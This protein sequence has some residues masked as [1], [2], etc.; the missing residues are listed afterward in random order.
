[1]ALKRS[2]KIIL[3]IIFIIL[4]WLSFGIGFTTKIDVLQYLFYFGFIFLIIGIVL[5]FRA[6]NSRN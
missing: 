3:S 2:Y 6:I 4:S 5:F 1:M